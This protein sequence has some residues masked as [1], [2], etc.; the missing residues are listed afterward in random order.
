MSFLRGFY[1]SALSKA[2]DNGM[3]NAA[4]AGGA[5]VGIGAGAHYAQTTWPARAPGVLDWMRRRYAKDLGA[6]IEATDLARRSGNIHAHLQPSMLTSLNETVRPMIMKSQ[7]YHFPAKGRMSALAGLGGVGIAAALLS[8]AS[9]ATMAQL[10][11][12]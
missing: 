9:P 5:G 11:E 2:A 3:R 8:K 10:P 1:A 4:I 12:L 6:D 7:K